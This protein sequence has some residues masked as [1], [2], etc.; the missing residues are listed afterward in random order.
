LSLGVQLAT[1]T[2]EEF[3]KVDGAIAISIE[4]GVEGVGLS[5]GNLDTVLLETDKEFTLVDLSVSIDGV[6]AS[7][8][9]T[10][11]SDG[12]GTS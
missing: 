2:N 3:V 9:A 6:E 10:K 11:S 1:N 5:L 12:L 4:E 8:R 7:E